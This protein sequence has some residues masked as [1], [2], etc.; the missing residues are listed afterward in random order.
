MRSHALKSL[1]LVFALLVSIITEA[2]EFTKV[3]VLLSSEH[4]ITLRDGVRHPTGYFLSELAVPLKAVMDA[5]VTPV[6]ANPKGN[7]PAM[8]KISDQAL[9]FGSEEKHR[10]MR[11]WIDTLEGLKKPVRVEEIV[12]KGIGE[13]AGVFVPGGHA[14]MEDLLVDRNVGRMLKMFHDAGKPTALICHGPIA[15][16]AS[17]ENPAAFVK[18]MGHMSLLESKVQVLLRKKGGAKGRKAKRYV[19]A[20]RPI[21][22]EIGRVTKELETLSR[23]WPYR[24]YLMTSFSTKEEQQ[25]EPDG[26]DNALGGF[27]Q[28]YPDEALGILGGR[29]V[30]RATK[31]Q[32]HVVRDRE[33]ITGQNP[34]SDEEFA[35]SFV[36]ALTRAPSGKKQ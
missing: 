16:V 27:V 32:S 11:A 4:K 35:K 36:D 15:L 31:W 1:M 34:M 13:Y 21:Q 29:V 19:E 20:I 33:L 6:F 9:W 24:G 26:A 17:L 7:P 3:L 5:G 12:A 28:F 23:D 2:A 10:T 22:E 8:D 25:E 14:P 18:A 30:V